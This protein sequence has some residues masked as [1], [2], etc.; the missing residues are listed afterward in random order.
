MKYSM[1]DGHSEAV[2]NK[3]VQGVCF[4]VSL[5]FIMKQY[6]KIKTICSNKKKHTKKDQVEGVQG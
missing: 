6:T 2:L 5:Y 4:S 1:S 3:K